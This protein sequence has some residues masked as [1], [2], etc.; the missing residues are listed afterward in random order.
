VR[1]FVFYEGAEGG[2]VTDE[3]SDYN[4]S[5]VRFG[6]PYAKRYVSGGNRI[7]RGND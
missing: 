2:E 5:V 6:G 4:A 3:I 7:V 1:V